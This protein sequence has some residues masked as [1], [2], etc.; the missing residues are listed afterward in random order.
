MFNLSKPN[1]MVIAWSA[2]TIVSLACLLTLVTVGA[3]LVPALI[4]AAVAAS[5]S[6]ILLLVT[7]QM[8]SDELAQWRTI[9]VEIAGLTSETKGLFVQMA[10]EFNAQFACIKAENVQVR[11][12]LA[13][14]ID[15]LV[16]SFT[17]LEAQTRAQQELAC[18]LTKQADGPAR[19]A[20]REQ[21]EAVNFEAFLREI[22][23]EIKTF[24]DGTVQS[25]KVVAA[26]LAKMDATN[27]TFGT[28]FET[29]GEVEKIADQTNLLALNAAIE[30]AR[31]GEAGRGFAV[32]AAEVRKL[33]ARSHSFSK[34]IWSCVNSVAA[35]LKTA[36]ESI[37]A[38]ASQDMNLAME[39]KSRMDDT[40]LKIS[41][42]N[43]KTEQAVSDMSGIA[44]RVGDEV[45]ACITSLQFQDMATQVLVH[46]DDRIKLLEYLLTN[47]AELSLEQEH[48]GTDLRTD[49]DLRLR[50][51][52]DALAKAGDLIEK[53]GHNPVKQQ[54]MAMG[55]VELF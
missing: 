41:A 36:E 51:F 3:G 26:L 49:C 19:S 33:S 46:M 39:S 29:L 53:A 18:E 34:E 6:G 44:E 12:L 1:R 55:D 35:S 4:L 43:Q 24:V 50:H 11:E 14:A 5:W 23:A 31:A 40:M 42:I 16:K 38:M 47:L 2:G 13:D 10:H 37:N 15:K 32:V 48:S 45:N 28:I 8:R 7:R 17:S 21:R 52:K 30:S 22:A 9:D 27:T 25:S 54:S 20:G